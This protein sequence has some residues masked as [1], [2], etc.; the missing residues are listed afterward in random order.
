MGATW[1]IT[2]GGARGAKAPAKKPALPHYKEIPI[3]KD[4]AEGTKAFAE[5]Y[6][7]MRAVL[8]D[9]GLMKAK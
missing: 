1:K 3:T 9:N 6:N 4:M 2:K 8:L 7:A 5:Q